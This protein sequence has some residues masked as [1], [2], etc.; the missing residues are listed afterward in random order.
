MTIKL[1]RTELYNHIW[2]DETSKT[3]KKLNTTADKVKSAAIKVNILLPNNAYW[4]HL[5]MG[6]KAIQ[7]RLPD[8][9]NQSIVSIPERKK[10]MRH[11]QEELKKQ[12]ANKFT[13]SIEL[14]KVTNFFSEISL[15]NTSAI[16][17]ALAQIRVPKLYQPIQ[18]R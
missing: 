11:V 1:T 17:Q 9:T 18:N 16:N 8:P 12:T 15:K 5:H 7:T 2:K 4:G 6:T 14:E 13:E 3:A 10:R